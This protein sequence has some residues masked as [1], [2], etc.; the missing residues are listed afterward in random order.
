MPVNRLRRGLHRVLR[1][2]PPPRDAHDDDDEPPV[3]VDRATWDAAALRRA[4]EAWQAPAADEEAEADAPDAPADADA[5]A[6][7]PRPTEARAPAPDRVFQ[8]DAPGP[9]DA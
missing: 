7:A 1:L 3:L 5:P 2:A 6:T 9:G 4:L 8:R